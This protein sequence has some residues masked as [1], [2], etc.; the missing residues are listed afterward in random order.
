MIS[1][2]EEPSFSNGL[3]RLGLDPQESDCLKLEIEDRCRAKIA[4]AAR[5]M[6]M[7]RL[8][9]GPWHLWVWYSVNGS[10]I[11]LG[12]VMPDILGENR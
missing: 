3:D 4:R 5:G 8:D 2:V 6:A 11:T 12:D 1:F 9:W 7:L 10:Q